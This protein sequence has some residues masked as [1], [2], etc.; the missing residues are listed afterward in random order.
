MI[1][2]ILFLTGLFVAVAT[3]VL[4]GYSDLKGMVIP[5]S[6][7]VIVVAAFVLTYGAL[8]LFGREDVFMHIGS[9]VLAALIVFLVTLVMFA[10]RAIGGADSKLATAFALW[11]GIPG[12]Y[13]FLF[14]MSVVG[15][16]LAF[17]ALG[18]RKW[19]PVKNP[20]QDSWFARAQAGESK[21][22]YGV[23]IVFGAL[24][25]FYQLGYFNPELLSSFLMSE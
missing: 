16:V 12:L 9:H 19:K 10:V 24:V 18:L 17:V 20:P 2:L 15:G 4:S 3:G 14:Y 7:S 13:P 22:P 21:I 25:S 23:A 5:N 6:Y 1:L 8:W 11:C